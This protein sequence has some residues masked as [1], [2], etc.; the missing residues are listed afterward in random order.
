MQAQGNPFLG[1]VIRPPRSQY[2]VDSDMTTSHNFGGK[3]Y[4][5]TNFVIKNE[6]Q[7]NL[8][9]SFTTI[10]DLPEGT[11]RPCVVYMHGNAGNK[12]EGRSYA[13]VLMPLG[14]DLFTFDF[15][16]CGNSDG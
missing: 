12:H 2:P 11:Q 3:A 5:C 13:P 16:G 7:E 8:H 15:S 4:K 10:Q 9:C 6:K 14:F 1:L